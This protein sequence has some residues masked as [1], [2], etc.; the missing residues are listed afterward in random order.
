MVVKFGIEIEAFANKKV[1]YEEI[2]SRTLEVQGYHRGNYG[3]MPEMPSWRI[4]SDSSIAPTHNEFRF[5]EKEVFEAVSR[6]FKINEWNDVFDEF[7]VYFGGEKDVEFDKVLAVNDN[8][9]CH[10]H[11]SSTTNSHKTFLSYKNLNMIKKRVDEYIQT[12]HPAVFKSFVKAYSRIN[13]RSGD[14]YCKVV[15]QD[16][17][18]YTDRRVE[19]NMTNLDHNSRGGIEWRAFNISGIKTWNQLYDILL[20]TFLIIEGVIKNYEKSSRGEDIEISIPKKK[21]EDMY[22][23]VIL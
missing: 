9:G 3:H 8:C 2:K 12:N 16:Y 15:K 14:S 22:E 4:E 7:K 1:L 20:N 10:I 11:F 18:D 23:L 19:W 17:I 21:V 6:T 13:N 5:I